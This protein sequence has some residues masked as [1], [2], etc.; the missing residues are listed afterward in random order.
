MDEIA[1]TIGEVI[2][3]AR[4]SAKEMVI[5]LNTSETVEL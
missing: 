2:I 4:Y 5:L 3:A 1:Q